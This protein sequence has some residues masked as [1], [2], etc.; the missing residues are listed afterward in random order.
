MLERL[1]AGLQRKSIPISPMAL[2]LLSFMAAGA[3][4]SSAELIQLSYEQYDPDE[5]GDGTENIVAAALVGSV[6]AAIIGYLFYWKTRDHARL[7]TLAM[8]SMG[9]YASM[10]ALINFT[11]D[12]YEGSNLAIFYCVAPLLAMTVLVLMGGYKRLGAGGAV[13]Q[14]IVCSFALLSGALIVVVAFLI[15]YPPCINMMGS[16]GCP[17]YQPLNGIV[18][19]FVIAGA[20]TLP[21]MFAAT[22]VRPRPM[23]QVPTG[24]G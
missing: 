7:Y 1:Q 2:L 11:E 5:Y 16:S 8:A 23:A 24:V 13:L 12:A 10:Y 3:A 9:A 22:R 15:T 19:G 6:S 14:S 20:S 17:E 4:L 18:Y 21:A